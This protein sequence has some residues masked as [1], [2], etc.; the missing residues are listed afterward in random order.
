MDDESSKNFRNNHIQLAIVTSMMLYVFY[1]L[2]GLLKNVKSLSNTSE[3]FIPFSK[4]SHNRVLT[5][6]LTINYNRSYESII[7]TGKTERIPPND[8][9]SQTMLYNF[10]FTEYD[11][12]GL[13]S[14]TTYLNQ[15]ARIFYEPKK[16]SSYSFNFLIKRLNPSNYSKFSL[17]Y[18]INPS[19]LTGMRFHI[20]LYDKS[21]QNYGIIFRSIFFV[22]SLLC[23][24]SFRKFSIFNKILNIMI[25]LAS[26][27]YNSLEYAYI[28]RILVS[29]LVCYF[30]FDTAR[31]SFSFL[32]RNIPNFCYIGLGVTFSFFS[33]MDYNYF[34]TGEHLFVMYSTGMPGDNNIE[35][36]MFHFIN[37][38]FVFTIF[39][40]SLMGLN[41]HYDSIYV[42]KFVIFCCYGLCTV[43]NSVMHMLKHVFRGKKYNPLQTDFLYMC[44]LYLSATLS[45]YITRY[46]D[47]VPVDNKTK[48]KALFAFR[49]LIRSI[50]IF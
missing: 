21:F 17:S 45:L 29:L 46:E 20:F 16:P 23:V 44:S 38:I 27:P 37:I 35:V 34:S 9:E 22:G 18:T 2:Y 42:C 14:N 31:Y 7:I 10:S 24:F 3:I 36:M 8:F 41:I 6:E 33:F 5:T 32:C 40:V 4:D 26:I 30:R 49:K 13:V 39:C 48:Y 19:L 11:S 12:I 25:I 50:F 1:V 28:N 47:L 15:K 43:F